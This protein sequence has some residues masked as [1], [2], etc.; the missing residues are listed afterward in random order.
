M[1]T[2]KTALN[3]V[4]LTW[5]SGAYKTTIPFSDS[6]IKSILGRTAYLSTDY[7]ALNP[8]KCSFSIYKN[9]MEELDILSAVTSISGPLKL[10]PGMNTLNLTFKQTKIIIS[11]KKLV[12]GGL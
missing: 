6:I 11:T 3:T 4:T 10:Y 5:G 12:L 2:I 7:L 9:G 1:S 8:A